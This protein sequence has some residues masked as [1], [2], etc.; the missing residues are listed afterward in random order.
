MAWSRDGHWHRIPL[1]FLLP[2]AVL[3]ALETN[4]PFLQLLQARVGGTRP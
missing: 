2:L 4:T 1:Q 3:E